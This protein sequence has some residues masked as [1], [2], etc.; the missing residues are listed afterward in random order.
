[1]GTTR[2]VFI[3]GGSATNVNWSNAQVINVA[4]V[5]SNQLAITALAA[6]TASVPSQCGQWHREYDGHCRRGLHGVGDSSDRIFDWAEVRY[7]T[8]SRRRRRLA[9]LAGYYANIR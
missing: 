6:G 2:N 4:F 9:T 8:C 5:S 3:V 1:V 7:R